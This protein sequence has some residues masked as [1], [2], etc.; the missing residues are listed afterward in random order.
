MDLGPLKIR[1]KLAPDFS[2][3]NHIKL[4][5]ASYILI[6]EEKKM[7]C[8]CLRSIKVLDGYSSN[9]KN[10]LSLKECKL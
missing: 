2:N 9:M 1:D 4:P 7:F 8:E 3:K 6:R 5:P 10:P